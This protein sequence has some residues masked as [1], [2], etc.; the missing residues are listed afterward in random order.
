MK[1][2]IDQLLQQALSPGEE[3][4]ARLNE[5]ILQAAKE[6]GT[7]RKK[8]KRIPV[9]IVAAALALL[10]GSLGVFAGWKYLSP[11]RVA[12][13]VFQDQLLSSAFQTE[14]AVLVNET[15]E[16]G[17]YKITLLGIVSGKGISE[18]AELDETGAIE[19]NKT[20]AVIAIEN[21]DGTPRPEVSDEAYG[22]DDF[23]VSPYIKG[24]DMLE[25]NISTMGGGYTEAV[26]DGI[27]YRIMECDN[28][29]I[30]AHR[31]LYI[32][33]N[34]GIAPHLNAFVIDEETGEITRNE[35]YEG[36]SALFELPIPAFKGNEEAAKAYLES[37][38]GP[39][40]AA[41]SQS[42][43]ETALDRVRKKVASWTL[44]DFEAN[45]KCVVKKELKPDQD[46]YISYSYE[47]EN[48]GGSEA[49]ILA[50]E[51]LTNEV[52]EGEQ[53][54]FLIWGM[55]GEEPTCIETFEGHE[56]G[57]ITL[58]VYEYFEN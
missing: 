58:R 27:Q 24:M 5:K 14:N 2:E 16:C 53:T 47:L 43:E 25:Y 54:G 38:N 29:E 45:S 3:P 9:G 40:E 35:S 13:E 50:S 55:W 42:G 1:Y 28:V 33:V 23:Y 7:M 52:F 49:T 46:G 20:Y 37:M 4:D 26:V 17:D 8:V 6:T 21:A 30:F 39:E 12:D 44:E 15:Q 34:E 32:G 19:D 41:D 48:M 31:G 18:Y 51:I 10:I 22:Q 36:V 11:D 56:D 57:S